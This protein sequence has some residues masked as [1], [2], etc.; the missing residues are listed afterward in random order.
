LKILKTHLLILPLTLILSLNSF[1]ADAV[2][3]NKGDKCPFA[4]TLLSPSASDKV[5]AALVNCAAV[6]ATND[7][8]QKS[9]LL[10]KQNETYYIK[11][12]SELKT[13][14]TQLDTALQKANS[15]ST[16]VKILWFGLG[17]IVT[18]AAVHISK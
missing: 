13:Q 14:N 12:T 16:F 17:V 1:A 18:G 10:Y 3:L 9:I 6:E 8:Y 5:V 2:K 11:E 7:S 4:G 15:N